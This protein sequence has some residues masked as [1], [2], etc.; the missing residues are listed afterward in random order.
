[1]K[2]FRN[3]RAFALLFAV[4]V[5]VLGFT[6]LQAPNTANARPL[7]CYRVCSLIPPYLCWDVCKPCPTLPPGPLEP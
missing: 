4:L 3:L 5:L 6:V 2:L 1:M 7:C